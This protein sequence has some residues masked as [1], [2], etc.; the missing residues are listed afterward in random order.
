MPQILRVGPYSIY[1]WSNKG[2]PVNR[3]MSISQK[4]GQ[5]AQQPNCG[6]QA[7]ERFFFATTIQKFLETF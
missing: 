7:Q 5:Q 6:L 4:A 2:K 1:F 3:F